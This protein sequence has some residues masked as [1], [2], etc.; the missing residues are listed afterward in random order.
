M[1]KRIILFLLLVALVVGGGGLANVFFLQEEKPMIISSRV[2]VGDIEEAVL[3]SG[4]LKPAKLV[5]VG[6]QVSGRITSV[7]VAPG[8][9]V[10][11]GDLIAEID[12]VTPR[13]DLQIAKASLGKIKAQRQEKSGTLK[14]AR[15]DSRDRRR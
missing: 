5:A 2:S 10:A 6:A 9:T 12:S 14:Q 8:Q 1:F 11:T 4:I 3:T 15:L 13:H 7:S